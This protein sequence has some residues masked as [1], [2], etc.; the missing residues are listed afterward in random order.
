MSVDIALTLAYHATWPLA[1]GANITYSM[2]NACARGTRRRYV[3]TTIFRTLRP[4]GILGTVIAIFYCAHT[5]HYLGLAIW[6]LNLTLFA[7]LWWRNDD[8]DDGW[9]NLRKKIKARW[10]ARAGVRCLAPV[11]AR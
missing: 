1:I 5:S 2:R 11:G 7:W 3:L 9:S 8:E 4:P 10:R 6:S